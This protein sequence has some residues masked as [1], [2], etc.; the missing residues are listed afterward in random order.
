MKFVISPKLCIGASF[1]FGAIAPVAASVLAPAAAC[2]LAWSSGALLIGGLY[3]AKENT[4]AK[5]SSPHATK[6]LQ[7]N[8]PPQ[9]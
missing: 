1:L 2:F 9:P 8:P 7:P 3:K 5:P 6:L 4:G